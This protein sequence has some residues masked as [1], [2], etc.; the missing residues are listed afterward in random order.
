MIVK[1][2]KYPVTLT[3]HDTCL[4]YALRRIGL[5]PVNYRYEDLE[6]DFHMKP[7]FFGPD[8]NSGV[9][10]LWDSNIEEVDIPW[11]ITVDG[12]IVSVPVKRRIHVGVYEGDGLV[13]DCSRLGSPSSLPQLKMRHINDIRRQPDKILIYK[14]LDYGEKG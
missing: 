9:L 5:Q 11:H 8:C 13:S 4:S 6:K 14:H 3:K 2:K 7:F 12:K 1:I 10:L